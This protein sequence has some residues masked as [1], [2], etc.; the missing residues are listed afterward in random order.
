MRRFETR[1]RKSVDVKAY[2]HI[3]TA[4]DLAD[5]PKGKCNRVRKFDNESWF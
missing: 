1:D 2:Q 3:P 5:I 4:S